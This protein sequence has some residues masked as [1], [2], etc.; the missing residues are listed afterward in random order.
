MFIIDV[1]YNICLCCGA[2]MCLIDCLWQLVNLS[3]IS[4]VNT[5]LTSIF[6]NGNNVN[7][8]VSSL[9]KI[10]IMANYQLTGH[11]PTLFILKCYQRALIYKNLYI[12]FYG[13]NLKS[14]G[15]GDNGTI[16]DLINL[17]NNND[18]YNYYTNFLNNIVNQSNCYIAELW[19]ENN[20][21]SHP[22]PVYF[23]K[24]SYYYIDISVN[25]I[26]QPLPSN[27]NVVILYLNHNRFYGTIPDNLIA[28]TAFVDTIGLSYNNLH[29][30]I[31]QELFGV[32]SNAHTRL[33]MLSYNKLT[34]LPQKFT[35]NPSLNYVSIDHNNI[36]ENNIGKWLNNFFINYTF[37][38]TLTL[39][40]NQGIKGNIGNWKTNGLI[41]YGL[42]T[43]HDCNIYGTI[44]NQL[45]IIPYVSN[46]T[47]STYLTMY[48][49]RISGKFPDNL[50]VN[51]YVNDN[52]SISDTSSWKMITKK[53][54]AFM[55]L[56]N[57]FSIDD[58]IVNKYYYTKTNSDNSWFETDFLQARNLYLNEDEI[59][60]LY[61]FFTVVILC[62]IWLLI[63]DLY[64]CCIVK[65]T[66]MH[67]RYN[68]SKEQQ[69]ELLLGPTNGIQRMHSKPNIELEELVGHGKYAY[70]K[71]SMSLTQTFYMQQIKSNNFLDT[72]EIIL[73]MISNIYTLIITILLCSLYYI[74]SNY[75]SQ[76]RFTSHFSLTYWIISDND[77]NHSNGG[78]I[79]LQVSLCVL[80]MLLNT[81]F[82][83]Q[84]YNMQV[85]QINYNY[86]H[87]VRNDSIR[88]RKS[89]CNINNCFK[90]L[91][92]LQSFRYCTNWYVIKSWFKCIFWFI[93]YLFSILFTIAATISENVPMDM[94][95]HNLDQILNGGLIV[96]LT[97]SSL[98]I[99][100]F[101][102]ESLERII[103]IN[104]LLL[105]NDKDFQNNNYNI[106]TKDKIH[107]AW[108]KKVWKYRPT[109]VL[110]CRS[111]LTIVIPCIISIALLN[112]CGSLWSTFWVKCNDKS[113]TQFNS[114][115]KF[116][117]DE[118]QISSQSAVCGT[119][120]FNQLITNTSQR[121][122][123]LRQFWDWW[124]P[125]ICL[126]LILLTMHG[127][128]K[129]FVR[130]YCKN[131]CDLCVQTR[132]NNC[133]NYI[134]HI[135][136]FCL[137]KSADIEDE[138]R[139]ESE[140]STLAT[141]LEI[142][143]IFCTICPYIV[144]LAGIATLTL[145]YYYTFLLESKLTTQK[146]Q[147][148]CT[149]SD[150]SNNSN[151]SDISIKSH[152]AFGKFPINCLFI[153]LCIQQIILTSFCFG[154]FDIKQRWIVYILMAF[155]VVID[156]VYIGKSVMVK[157]KMSTI[158]L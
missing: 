158:R 60:I 139:I 70:S 65:P 56:G 96:V 29:G 90:N 46:E 150:D 36:K 78:S 43:L 91:F 80:Y 41:L 54:T 153:S 28:E 114:A 55:I 44:S 156:C 18:T 136:K 17:N 27:F 147:S 39:D 19:L 11:I 10:N 72:I 138:L 63:R 59:V 130:K 58:K 62:Y 67:Y 52:G 144:A 118:S 94:F 107:A 68:N 99:V 103:I 89:Y 145:K 131:Q 140:F 115:K 74:D 4:I 75:F 37:V 40:H 31:P 49:N 119:E 6:S 154:E 109:V 127:M 133:N 137:Y 47:D 155:F 73:N 157:I 16:S 35:S 126:K 3:T 134:C 69:Q 71:E 5:Q 85:K 104:R 108:K 20:I 149:E 57:L 92:T 24:C 9:I 76:G 61:M 1:V 120:S 112:D 82:I 15:T 81:V 8:N 33:L 97:V 95:G 110:I 13:N 64:Q 132:N 87:I 125:I 129:M 45:K 117:Y 111:F 84:L 93:A 142:V 32:G 22:L 30:P 66:W 122:Q 14:Y 51:E 124:V 148:I 152:S 86:L 34:Q 151:D 98:Y 128:Y 106:L 146:K 12:A 79:I 26:E 23:N 123:C 105:T 25:L 42:I 2:Q 113:S 50:I 83:I 88:I 7:F 102:S 77:D 116:L 121:N 135:F 100:R 48:N 143:F 53:F 101:L 141:N 21:I 38:D